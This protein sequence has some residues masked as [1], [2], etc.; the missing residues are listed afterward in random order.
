MSRK[1]PETRMM[2]ASEARKHFAETVN[3]AAK[4]ISRTIIEK[5]GLPSA[6]LISAS[7]LERLERYDAQREED[8]RALDD[9]RAA[10]A[11]VDPD[12]LIEQFARDLAETRAEMTR[13]REAL[14]NKHAGVA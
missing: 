13:E 7:D 4:G 12:E 8:F 14:R 2:S 5:N 10:F 6:A 11:D 3:D 9:L 1:K